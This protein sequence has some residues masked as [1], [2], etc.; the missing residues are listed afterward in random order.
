M[1]TVYLIRHGSIDAMR[2][3]LIGRTDAALNKHGRHE[4]TLTAA[5]C[6][7]L[8]IGLV[9]SSPRRRARETAE[10]IAA[11]LDCGIEVCDD[12]DEIDYGAWSGKSFAELAADPAWRRFNEDRDAAAIPGGESLDAVSARITSGLDAICARTCPGDIAV[13][14]HAEIIRGALLLA[15][16]RSWSS[17][18]LYQ[19]E[20]ASITAMRWR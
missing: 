16:S 15:H 10:I 3:R 18:S 14:T 4:A 1:R 17:W 9:G 2:E 20:P 19:P 13:V 6:Q 8:G 11:A 7:R 5:A 12:F